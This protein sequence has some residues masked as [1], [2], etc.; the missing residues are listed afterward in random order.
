MVHKI[1]EAMGQRED[2]Y[3]LEGMTEADEG[4]FTVEPSAVERG[5]Q[6]ARAW[7]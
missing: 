7:Q 3:T 4:Y 6:K 5:K 2:R 1:R